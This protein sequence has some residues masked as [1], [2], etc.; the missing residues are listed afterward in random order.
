MK[1][2]SVASGSRKRRRRGYQPNK[3]RL[4]QEM[5]EASM[6]AAE[7]KSDATRR[8]SMRKMTQFDNFLRDRF[9]SIKSVIML[10]ASHV[11]AYIAHRMLK[12]IALRTIQN[13]I[14][15]IRVMLRMAG[16]VALADSAEIS[17]EALGISKASRRGTKVAITDEAYDLAVIQAFDVDPGLG[18]AL[19]LQRTLGLR[20]LEAIRS[21]PSLREWLVDLKSRKQVR[22]VHGTKGGRERMTWVPN[23]ECAIEAVE[24]AIAVSETREGRLLRGTLVQAYA[25]YGNAMRRRVHIQGHTLRYAFIL[26]RVLAYM[27][28]GLS[29]E[30]ALAWTSEDVGHGEG[31]GR[32]IRNVY[33]QNISL[34]PI[35]RRKRGKNL[36]PQRKGKHPRRKTPSKQ[37][38]RGLL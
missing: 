36:A 9:C 10:R 30:Q 31:R 3:R 6:R 5:R 13:D 25:F 37:R 29:L 1:Q 12:E 20:A 18:C 34:P 33:L 15:A 35:R 23:F 26:E 7:G 21:G 4:K 2:N 38:V 24:R 17:S 32:W 19:Q 27:A 14:S 11:I 16:L 8:S 28:E 22:V